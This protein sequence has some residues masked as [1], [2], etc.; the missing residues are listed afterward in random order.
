MVIYHKH[1]LKPRH[2][3]GTNDPSNLLEV[4]V[5][6]HATI[7]LAHWIAYGRW[8]DKIAWKSLSYQIT[9]GM[10]QASI[11]YHKA[12]VADGTH[13]LLGIRGKEVQRK[14]VANGTHPFLGGKIQ[15][16][17][18]NRL[19]ENGTHHLL[20]PEANRRK[21]EK[22]IHPSQKIRTCLYCGKQ[23]KSPGMFRRHFDN[24]KHKK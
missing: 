4:T 11:E 2:L 7:H 15:Q 16:K 13:H 17:T 10:R 22:G 8:Q 14:R 24:C 12:K 3:G 1:H 18:Q 6:D 23:G 5:Y 20:G 21:I 9:D 19:V